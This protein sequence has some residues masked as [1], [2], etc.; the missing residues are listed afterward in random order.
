MQLIKE[1]YRN[2]TVY[3]TNGHKYKTIHLSSN[4]EN[5]F[6]T[7]NFENPLECLTCL[8]LERMQTSENASQILAKAQNQEMQKVQK[9]L[10][11]SSAEWST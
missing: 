10:D 11:S 8:P 2:L 5:I 4:L 7:L 3:I 6:S 1:P 9:Q